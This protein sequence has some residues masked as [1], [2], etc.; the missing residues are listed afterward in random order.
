MSKI[1]RSIRRFIRQA[2]AGGMVQHTTAIDTSKLWFTPH[3]SNVHFAMD[4]AVHS[5]SEK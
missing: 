5:D 1:V 2:F 4:E 3:K